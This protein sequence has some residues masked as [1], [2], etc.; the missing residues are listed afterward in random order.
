[1]SSK[2]DNYTFRA[3]GLGNIISKSGKLTQGVQSHLLELFVEKTYKTRKEITSKYFEKGVLN[4]IDAIALI[5]R[6]LHPNLFLSKNHNR[7]QN[8]FV[9]GEIDLETKEIVYDAKNAWD[10]FTFEKSELSWIYEWQ[11]RAYMWLWNKP[12]ARLFYCLTDMPDHLIEN[13]AKRYWYR[14]KLD[15]HNPEGLEYEDVYMAFSQKYD[16]SHLSDEERFKVWEI[17]HDEKDVERMKDSVNDARNYLNQ[18]DDERNERISK[19]R[20]MM[21]LKVEPK[22]SKLQ[23]I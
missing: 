22:L 9:Q 15:I 3:S 1:M 12:K 14:E 6:T 5:N 8:D 18:L 19:N 17:N 20:V 16:F 23:K 21:G 10:Q 13:E 7:F 11:L 2:F 4:E